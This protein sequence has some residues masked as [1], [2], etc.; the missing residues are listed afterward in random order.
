M[1]LA[2]LQSNSPISCVALSHVEPDYVSLLFQG[3]CRHLHRQQ[4]KYCKRF[5]EKKRK[6]RIDRRGG[7]AEMEISIV[8]IFLARCLLVSREAGS[9]EGEGEMGGNREN[10]GGEASPTG[11]TEWSP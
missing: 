7:E 1:F 9:R 2:C 11:N 8:L 6:G 10:E 3:I 5:T 4:S